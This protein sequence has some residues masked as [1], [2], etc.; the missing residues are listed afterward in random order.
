MVLHYYVQ[1][2]TTNTVSVRVLDSMNGSL[3]SFATI[4]VASDQGN[5]GVSVVLM[6]KRPCLPDSTTCWDE[7][8][9]QCDVLSRLSFAETAAFWTMREW[10]RFPVQVDRLGH[11]ESGR[12]NFKCDQANANNLR[13]V[14]QQQNDAEEKNKRVV[15]K[16]ADLNK[17]YA[18]LTATHQLESEESPLN[19]AEADLNA[20]AS[21]NFLNCKT[22]SDTPENVC[23]A[24]AT[25]MRCTPI[26]ADTKNSDGCPAT[27]EDLVKYF[28][29]ANPADKTDI[30]GVV[31]DYGKGSADCHSIQIEI[32][33]VFKARH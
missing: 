11:Q 33:K 23:K 24:L 27:L 14:R 2:I 10:V 8:E 17:A 25:A 6:E 9:R 12:Y 18:A 22:G 5:S 1:Q 31:T 29:F 28:H 7:S 26:L 21:P 3:A 32:N 15:M 30:D 4:P 20:L 16:I 13:E 19:T